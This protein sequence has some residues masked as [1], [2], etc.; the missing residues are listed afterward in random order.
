[1]PSIL[2]RADEERARRRD[3]GEPEATRYCRDCHWSFC[4][5]SLHLSADWRCMRPGERVSLVTGIAEPINRFCPGE[6]FD[7][8]GC[9]QT[10]RFFRPI[11][12]GILRPDLDAALD[13][14]RREQYNALRHRYRYARDMERELDAY[15]GDGIALGSMA[16]PDSDIT[17]LIA[18]FDAQERQAR[19]GDMARRTRGPRIT[20]TEPEDL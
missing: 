13:V 4:E 10:G 7:S 8:E 19:A 12:G 6:R 5:G 16:H 15:S 20:G 11:A 3:E 14:V 9:G 17:E 2:D 18:T 1:M